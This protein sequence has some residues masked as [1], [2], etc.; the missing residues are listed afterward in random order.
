MGVFF[1]YVLASIPYGCAFSL[2]AVGLVLTYR[3]TGVFNFAFAAEAYAAT[4]IYSELITHGVQ[5]GWAAAI[6]VFVIAPI[7]GALLDFGLFSRVPPGNRT[8]KTIMALGLMVL[9]P[10]IVETA[11]P[12]NPPLPPAP[13]F[14]TSFLP[15]WQLGSN[16]VFGSAI[17]EVL[18]TILVLVG[19]VVLL[20][21]RRFGLPIRA[22]VESP[23]LLELSGVDA[24]WVL[25]FAW[26][27]STSLA[28]VAGVL[29][30]TG[31]GGTVDP[32]KYDL[33]LVASIAAAALAGLRN[34]PIAVLG[35]VLLGLAEGLVQGY[36][37]S[38]SLWYTAL[39]PSLPFLFLL[40][41]LIFHPTLRHLEDT[42]DP[43]AA[44]EPPPPVPAVAMRPPAVD[45]TIRRMRWPFLLVVVFGV[46]LFVPTDWTSTL[47]QGAA[48][49]IVFLS[50]TLL[51]GLAGQLS[52]AQWM[53][54]G[55]GAF[56]TAQLAENRHWP[57]LAAAL[58]GALVAGLAGWLAALPALRLRGL[59]V[60]LLTLCLALLGDNLLFPT[61]W[62]SNGSN[63]IS[64]PRPS[65]IFGFD[66]ASVNSEGFFVLTV[67][68]MVAVAGVVHLLLR[69]TTGRALTAVHASPIGASSSG[70]QTRR[71]TIL[72]FMLS[73][74]IAGLGGAFYAMN[75]QFISQDS[76]VYNFGPI[77][78]VIVVTIGSTTVEGAITAGMLFSVL[79]YAFTNVPQGV[80]GTQLK[81]QALTVILLSLGAFAYAKHPEGI[82]EYAKR[83]FA[84]TIFRAVEH[85]SHPLVSA[86]DSA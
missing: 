26:M 65:S 48:L 27:V 83:R 37:P 40:V 70:V 63:G 31:G 78:L 62:I 25:R 66:F 67:V 36:V 11:V 47:T 39:V 61:S 45:R 44:V 38:T 76:F 82:V 17:C 53:F 46:I 56:T 22:A 10:Q 7:F 55:I 1:G 21:T 60:A 20:R 28:A 23:K 85:H 59:P 29:Y 43:L 2:V 16:P 5:R 57:I 14:S 52:L 50:I 12:G 35:G 74:S 49:S 33:L 15:V 41:L 81:S 18:G 42:S 64:V 51:T 58:A 84:M 6:L 71:M 19:L 8:A 80:G 54:A 32:T 24:R 77:Y 30:Q 68:V 79:S 86:E 69:G 13:F 3:A 9:L 72:V 75:A 73:A 34:L 4:V